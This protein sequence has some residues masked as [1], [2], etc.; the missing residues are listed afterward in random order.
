M[1]RHWSKSKF[2]QHNFHYTCN[3]ALGK[4][5]WVIPSKFFCWRVGKR[6]CITTRTPTTLSAYCILQVIFHRCWTHWI[7]RLLSWHHT[8]QC[9]ESVAPR[10]F[11]AHLWAALCAKWPT[12]LS[13][14]RSRL[15]RCCHL[16]S[17]RVRF[18]IRALPSITQFIISFQTTTHL[19]SLILFP[20][21]SIA[22]VHPPRD[23]DL[24]NSF[25]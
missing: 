9:T 23:S 8:L 11:S 20:F 24:A 25:L 12:R 19:L 2:T 22:R 3:L 17:L 7:G 13:R 15:V 16:A 14:L 6:F 4:A 21:Q 18:S 1:R 10:Q 5:L